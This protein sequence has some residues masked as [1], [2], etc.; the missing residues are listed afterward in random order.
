MGIINSYDDV[1][2]IITDLSEEDIRRFVSGRE[3]A[4]I[5]INEDALQQN[6]RTRFGLKIY[7]LD[8]LGVHFDSYTLEIDQLRRQNI[9]V[10]QG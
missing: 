8:Q 5:N 6:Y 7:P 4:V 10:Y 2:M 3:F 1:N 9:F